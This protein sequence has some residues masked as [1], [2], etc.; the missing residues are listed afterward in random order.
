MN[1][2]GQWYI[3]LYN[4]DDSLKEN[5]EFRVDRYDDGTVTIMFMIIYFGKYCCQVPNIDGNNETVCINSG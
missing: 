3:I 2:E 4:G 5:Q 1:Q